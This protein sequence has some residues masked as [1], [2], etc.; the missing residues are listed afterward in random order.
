[1]YPRARNSPI[2][3]YTPRTRL[4]TGVAVTIYGWLAGRSPLRHL[5]VSIARGPI[6]NAC[7]NGKA[8]D[9]SSVLIE[10]CPACIATR[11]YQWHKVRLLTHDFRKDGPLNV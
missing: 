3:I 4:R 8:G 9:N 5:V 6:R 2:G 7:G 11:V 1:M 10:R